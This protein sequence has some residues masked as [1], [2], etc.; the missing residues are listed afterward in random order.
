MKRRLGTSD[1]SEVFLEPISDKRKEEFLS[2]AKISRDFHRKWSNA[3]S[4]PSQFL[5]YMGRIGNETYRCFFVCRRIDKKLV[6]VINVSQIYFGNFRNAYLGYYVFQPYARK[7]YMSA[8]LSLV[9]RKAFN[10][11]KLHRLEAN[12]QPGN[13]ASK[14]L[15]ARAGFRLEGFSK[16]YLKVDG[17]WCDHE[18]WA[19]TIEDW[20]EK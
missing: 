16:R 7:G 8:G 11:I 6:G 2:L 14:K 18:R 10:T 4:T 1:S 3:P 12:I 17:K 19:I 13:I 9:L 15:V 20:R 5:K